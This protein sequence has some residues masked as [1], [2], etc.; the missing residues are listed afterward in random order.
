MARYPHELRKDG[1]FTPSWTL[2]GPIILGRF[3]PPSGDQAGIYQSQ[4]LRL[5][6]RY[7]PEKRHVLEFSTPRLSRGGD[8]VRGEIG[9]GA[10]ERRIW[11]HSEG[12]GDDGAELPVMSSG[13]L[14]RRLMIMAP[15]GDEIAR[16]GKKGNHFDVDIPRE[17]FRRKQGSAPGRRRL[18]EAA[19]AMLLAARIE[20]F[21][22]RQ[23]TAAG[24]AAGAAAG[25][26]ASATAHA[27]RQRRAERDA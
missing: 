6:Y 22:K 13:M 7:A 18:Y 3:R 2:Q 10:G 11:I 4:S 16:I 20:Q 19:I 8:R 27:M 12:T 23:A 21:R 26:A 1:V 17:A 14:K 5:E 15:N 9:T 25:A 24:V